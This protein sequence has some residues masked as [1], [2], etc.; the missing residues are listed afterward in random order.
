MEHSS[1]GSGPAE[2]GLDL[3]QERIDL[4]RLGDERV[5]LWHP[6]GVLGV[7]DVARRQHH[8]GNVFGLGMISQPSYELEAVD[9]GHQAIGDDE[10]R[11]NP[12]RLVETIAAVAGGVDLIMRAAKHRLEERE[13]NGAV[14]DNE[15]A[16][17]EAI[18]IRGRLLGRWLRIISLKLMTLDAALLDF[19]I[20]LR[21]PW[22]DDVMLLASA[23][24]AAGFI[25]WVTAL[26]A[27]VF[28]ARRAAAWRMIL[29]VLFT[30][31]INDLALKPLVDR[32]RPYD[33]DP[34]IAV[35]DAKP[36]TPSFPSGHTAMAMAGAL[37]GSRMLSGSGWIWWPL[38]IVV[39][40]SRIYI[41]VHWPTDV[42]AGAIVGLTTGWFVLGGRRVSALALRPA[43]RAVSAL[44]S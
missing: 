10:I 23:I 13:G 30:Y 3:I 35:I 18:G 12:Q 27:M 32:A 2:Q 42:I 36:L 9:V 16:W 20:Q 41:G 24:G 21:R 39:A 14:V 5:G 40:V 44:P 43:D 22:L 25:W 4:H 33:V 28:P 11:P 31:A 17:A 34:A 1:A 19:A 6:P 38:A 7:L 15:Q 26:I 37:A 29:A 8:H